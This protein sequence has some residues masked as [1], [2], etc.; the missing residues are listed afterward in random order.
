MKFAIKL[1]ESYNE[2]K[3]KVLQENG[4]EINYVTKLNPSIVFASKTAGTVQEL[5]DMDIVKSA[6]AEK[7][8]YLN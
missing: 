5:L 4:Y 6:R 8:Y 3:H 1:H 7:N 2:Q